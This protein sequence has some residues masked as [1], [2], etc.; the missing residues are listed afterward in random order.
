MNTAN[1]LKS[2][3]EEGKFAVTAE[4]GPPKGADPQAVFKKAEIL[5]DNVDAVNVTDNQTAIVRMSS[6]AACALL[7]SAGL[8]P[9]LQM[10][11]ETV[12]ELRS[13]L[14]FL[15]RPHSGSGMCYVFQGIIRY[16]VTSPRPLAFLTWIPSSS[17]RWSRP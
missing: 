17:S 13:S 2:V 9:V 5:K 7:K 16:S 3:L 11:T 14:I 6:L 10:T 12:T 15:A 1:R 8:D 4:C